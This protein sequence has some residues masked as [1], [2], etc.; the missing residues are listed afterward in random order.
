MGQK[1]NSLGF[2]IGITSKHNSFWYAKPNSYSYFVKQDI[3]IRNYIKK[4]LLGHFVFNIVIRRKANLINIVVYVLKNSVFLKEDVGRKLITDLSLQLL[5][6]FDAKLS[7]L[8]FVEVSN[9][10]FLSSLLAEFIKQQLEKRVPFRK[11][12]KMSIVKVRQLSDKI[13][14]IKIQISGRLNGAEIARTEWV[15]EGRVP[16]HT[17]RANIDY[18]FTIAQT[19]FGVLGIKVWLYMS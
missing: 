6:K 18:S 13:K 14:G 7:S 3:F 16:L 8:N 17:L 15:R 11:V 5:I 12:I 2:R 9:T 10:D 4:V 1:I 19:V